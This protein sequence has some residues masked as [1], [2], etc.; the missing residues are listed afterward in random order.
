MMQFLAFPKILMESQMRHIL[1]QIVS[2][3]TKSNV[4]LIWKAF[5]QFSKKSRLK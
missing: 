2:L 3:E 5:T 1:E 4:D